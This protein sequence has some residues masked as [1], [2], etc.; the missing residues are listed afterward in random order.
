VCFCI[1]WFICRSKLQRRHRESHLYVH[2]STKEPSFNP[3]EYL[4]A[5]GHDFRDMLLHYCRFVM[6][7]NCSSADFYPLLVQKSRCFTFNSGRNRQKS[8]EQDERDRR[9]AVVFS[10]IHKCVKTSS[11]NFLVGKEC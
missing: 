2:Y 8:D 3:N 4:S 5:Y 1:V 10:W 7:E 9:V 6:V 11:A